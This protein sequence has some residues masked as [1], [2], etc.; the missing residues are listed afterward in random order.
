MSY[1]CTGELVVKWLVSGYADVCP[2]Y[3]SEVVRMQSGVVVVHCTSL[4]S[5]SNQSAVTIYPHCSRELSFR[6]YI[7]TILP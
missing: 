1:E 7:P 5:V 6:G 4:C 3:A 2:F